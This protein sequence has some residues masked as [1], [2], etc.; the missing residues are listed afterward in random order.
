MSISRGSG[1]APGFTHLYLREEQVRSTYESLLLAWRELEAISD[2]R[3]RD[4]KLGAAHHRVLFLVSTHPGCTMSDLLRR[5]NITKQSLNRV[6]QELVA[7]A[8]LEQRN[9]EQDKRLRLLFLTPKGHAVENAVFDALRE[10][11]T[12][13]YRDVGGQAV[14]GFRRV[15]ASLQSESVPL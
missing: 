9:S 7:R 15:L 12:M 2:A 1:D 3:L 13:A 6:L 11:M 10:R 14:D 5:L 4:E 8:Y